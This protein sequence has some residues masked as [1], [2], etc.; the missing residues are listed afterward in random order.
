MSSYA[1]SPVAYSCNVDAVLRKGTIIGQCGPET[2]PVDLFI[3]MPGARVKTGQRVRVLGLLEPPI[4]WTDVFGHTVY[5]AF[6]RAVFVDR[7]PPR[8]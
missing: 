1:G 4:P 2:E 8:R 5:Y 3:E 7:L 6:V